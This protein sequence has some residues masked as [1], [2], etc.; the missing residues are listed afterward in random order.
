MVHSPEL[1]FAELSAA[2]GR[3]IQG[4]TRAEGYTWPILVVVVV[5]VGD[6]VSCISASDHPCRSP[7]VR[8]TAARLIPVLPARHSVDSQ[9][10]LERAYLKLSLKCNIHYILLSRDAA[11]SHVLHLKPNSK[12]SDPNSKNG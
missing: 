1:S 10:A 5:Q 2:I 6:E 12:G 7:K 8:V 9:T 11:A 3:R 4:T